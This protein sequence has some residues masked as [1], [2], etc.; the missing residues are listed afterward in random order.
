MPNKRHPAR[1]YI[2]FWWTVLLKEKLT[3]I[4][5]KQGTSL[6]VLVTKVLRRYA[7]KNKFL[8]LFFLDFWL[9]RN[10]N[11]FFFSAFCSCSMSHC[12]S[13]SARMYSE[14]DCPRL[15]ASWWTHSRRCFWSTNVAVV[16]L[17]FLW[18][19]MAFDRNYVVDQ[20]WPYFKV[21][22]SYLLV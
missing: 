1:K 17:G 15:S 5:F 6:S 8:V 19:G 10:K 18:F 11:Y 2:G 16:W 20:P 21:F 22:L 9:N 13:S 4:A 7:N 12:R 14:V 3:K